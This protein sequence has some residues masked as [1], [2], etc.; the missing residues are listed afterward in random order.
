MKL[1]L[2]AELMMT[3]LPW[4]L[5]TTLHKSFRIKSQQ[6]FF[7]ENHCKPIWSRG[8][9]SFTIKH[10]L[11]YL[12]YHKA[13]FQPIFHFIGNGMLIN[14]FKLNVTKPLEEYSLSLQPFSQLTSDFNP[15][16][17]LHTPISTWL[18]LYFSFSHLQF[19][20]KTS[21]CS[22]LHPLYFSLLPPRNI[23]PSY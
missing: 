3:P 1:A 6:F 17:F 20:E 12:F 21:N 19:C 13:S 22:P 16:R 15:P 4:N 11:I 8:F 23:F 10:S 9:L 14:P 5:L 7:K 2:I 18:L